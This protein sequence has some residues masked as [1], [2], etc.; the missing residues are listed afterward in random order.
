[1]QTFIEPCFAFEDGLQTS[2]CETKSICYDN[3]REV[4]TFVKECEAE[5]HVIANDDDLT[6]N[7]KLS[8]ISAAQRLRIL[9]M[10]NYCQL[11]EARQ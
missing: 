5:T 11:F 1:M 7:V 6:M 2:R 3:L 8:Q 10:W 9:I 4:C